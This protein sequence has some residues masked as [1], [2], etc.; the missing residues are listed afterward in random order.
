MHINKH[1]ARLHIVHRETLVWARAFVS[2]HRQGFI[3]KKIKK[4]RK[5]AGGRQEQGKR[6]TMRTSSTI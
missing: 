3:K 6:L 2:A 5:K 4:G 1:P